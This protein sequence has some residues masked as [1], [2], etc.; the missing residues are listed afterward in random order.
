MIAAADVRFD[1]A[2]LVPAVVQDARTAQVLMVAWMN[3]E[4]VEATQ[5]TGLVTFWSRSRNELWQKGAT[6]GNTLTLVSMTLD[7]DGDTILV[8]A[9]P[10][11]PVCHTGTTTCFGDDTLQGFTRLEALWATI[12][13]RVANRPQGSYTA[14][15]VA[16]GP[17]GPGRKIVEEAT[18]VLLAMKDHEAGTAD[19]QRVAEEAADLVYHLLVALAERGITPGVVLE[20]LSARAR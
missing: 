4:A 18:E 10:A 14:A 9:T 19:D 3:V 20:E 8:T 16:E 7:C 1:D 13:S 15:L 6:T 5:R 2:G 12:A 17:E 11:G